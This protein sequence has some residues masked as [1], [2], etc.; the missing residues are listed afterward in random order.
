MSTIHAV[1]QVQK[2]SNQYVNFICLE[3]EMFVLLHQES[4]SISYHAPPRLSVA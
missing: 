4:S 2:L 1:Q 3:Y